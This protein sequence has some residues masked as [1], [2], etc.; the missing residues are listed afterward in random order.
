MTPISRWCATR[1]QRISRI[2]R[3]GQL[4]VLECT[5]Y[6]GTTEEIVVPMVEAAGFDDR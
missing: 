2:L 4:I 3:R 5:T 6:P 1:R